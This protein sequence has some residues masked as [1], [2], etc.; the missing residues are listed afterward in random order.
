MKTIILSVAIVLLL[1]GC[2]GTETTEETMEVSVE[3]N[4]VVEETSETTA[5]AATETTEAVVESAD[6]QEQED[7]R[8]ENNTLYLNEIT[9]KVTDVKLIKPG[10]VD[11]LD[12]P[13]LTFFFE[14]ENKSNRNFPVNLV[15]LDLV[16]ATQ[17]TDSTIESLDVGFT[18]IG[19]SNYGELSENLEVELKPGGTIEALMPYEVK[20]PDLPVTLTFIQS[21]TGNE[22]GRLV[23]DP[24]E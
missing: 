10:D 13:Q 23:V 22:I 5:E 17:E 20:Y 15:W 16:K 4:L 19:D 2:G 12:Q 24:I 7:V 3:E 8:F 9:L 14:L 21:S 11:F 1:T 6:A 18:Y